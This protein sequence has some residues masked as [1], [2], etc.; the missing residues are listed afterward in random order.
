MRSFMALIGARVCAYATRT[1]PSRR[2]RSIGLDRIVQ[3]VVRLTRRR[4]FPGSDP[5]LAQGLCREGPRNVGAIGDGKDARQ[6]AGD[7]HPRFQPTSPGK[8]PSKPPEPL[9]RQSAR[10]HRLPP[11]PLIWD[12]LRQ[13][14]WGRTS[15][16]DALDHGAEVVERVVAIGMAMMRV[17]G[18]IKVNCYLMLGI[19]ALM[20]HQIVSKAAG[21]T[22]QRK[23][24]PPL[25][26][27]R[28]T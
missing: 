5:R 12:S 19:L 15:P 11:L 24:R 25:G 18:G 6:L 16:V 23:N 2:M 22:D 27:R 1:L 28:G 8:P 10:H 17:R 13:R 26:L 20:V 3:K 21:S 9:R 14:T 7:R 4:P